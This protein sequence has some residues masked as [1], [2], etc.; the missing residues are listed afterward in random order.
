M[1]EKPSV[2]EVNGARFKFRLHPIPWAVMENYLT[3]ESP[4]PALYTRIMI[5]S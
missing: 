2:L 5:V 1:I 4:F 3:P